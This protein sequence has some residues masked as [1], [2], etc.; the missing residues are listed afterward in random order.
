MCACVCVCVRACAC[1]R[2]QFW[3]TEAMS[4]GF[5]YAYAY[6]CK[7]YVRLYTCLYV[8]PCARLY[9]SIL[10]SIRLYVFGNSRCHFHTLSPPLSLSLRYT[11]KSHTHTH[12][13]THTRSHTFSFSERK[14]LQSEKKQLPLHRSC[15]RLQVRL[16]S[17]AFS[18]LLNHSQTKL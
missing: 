18:R 1:V 16:L 12:T 3:T 6:A 14:S 10:P 13:H 8:S 2:A 11:P 5:D 4:L 15:S 9:V 7:I 17:R